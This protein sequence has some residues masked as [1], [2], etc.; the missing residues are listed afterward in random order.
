MTS[1][2]Q[3]LV[4][5]VLLSSTTFADIPVEKFHQLQNE[6]RPE[7]GELW[8]TIPWKTSVLAAQQTASKETKPIFIWA[9]D[10]HPLGCT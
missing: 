7:T 2:K 10:G 3:I 5:I 4:P 6:L 1:F 8:R 9:M